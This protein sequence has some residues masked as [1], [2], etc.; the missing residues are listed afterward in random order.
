MA[1]NPT[2]VSN[3]TEV[4]PAPDLAVESTPSCAACQHS[5]DSHDPLGI[6]FCAVTSDRNLDR[7]CICADEHTT[8]QHYT[9]Y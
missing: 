9:R 2:D 6:R 5:L 3:S 1:S 8:T 4:F 7:K